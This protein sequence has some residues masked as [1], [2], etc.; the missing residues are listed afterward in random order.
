MSGPWRITFDTNPDDCNRHCTMCEQF[1]WASPHQRARRQAGLP[2]RR[3]PFELLERVVRECQPHGLREII[4]ST[5]GEPLLYRD[6]KRII[7]LCRETGVLLN[8]TTNASFPRLGAERWAELVVPVTSDVKFSWNGATQVTQESIMVGSSYPQGLAGI[9]DFVR[10]RDAWAAEHGHRCSLTLQLTFLESNVDELVGMVRLAADL[11]LD[12]VKGHHV[13]TH[14]DHLR[15]LSMRRDGEAIA[16]WNRVA[17][18]AIEV[19]A[20]LGLRLDNVHPLAPEATEDLDPE[21]TCPFLDHEAWV[22]PEG[23]FHPCCAPDE[24]RRALGDFGTVHGQGL[25]A[26]WRSEPYRELVRSYRD[27]PLCRS[28]NMRRRE[29]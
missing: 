16:H 28:C 18:E 20:A 9:R 14:F 11:G 13:W 7:V 1:S 19:A 10:V 23:R 4:P 24:Q 29:I 2:P 12:R 26:I 5:M 8:L 27:H 17:G 21:A 22:D 6:F 15:A 3:M 25:L